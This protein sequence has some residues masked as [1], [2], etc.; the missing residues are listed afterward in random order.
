VVM[1]SFTFWDIT[2]CS[3]LKV[4]LT[5]AFTLV[6]FP[7]YSSTLKKEAMCSSETMVD[8][9]WTTR[10]YIPEDKTLHNHN[11]T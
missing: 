7:A 6:S 5:P 3:P 9:Q 1:K 10:R 11:C 2:P 8:F 4:C